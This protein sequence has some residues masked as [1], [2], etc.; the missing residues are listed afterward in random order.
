LGGRI[1]SFGS[2][3]AARAFKKLF[4]NAKKNRSTTKQKKKSKKEKEKLTLEKEGK[5]VDPHSAA[6]ER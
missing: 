6:R 3:C 2:V 4:E 1:F 5:E